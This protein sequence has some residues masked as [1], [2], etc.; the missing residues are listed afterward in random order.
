METLCPQRRVL[1][2]MRGQASHTKAEGDD[3]DTICD[4]RDK[5]PETEGAPGNEEEEFVDLGSNE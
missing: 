2:S 5:V 4:D 1:V 3:K